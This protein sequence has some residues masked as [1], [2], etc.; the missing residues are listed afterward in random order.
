MDALYI[1]GPPSGTNLAA[2][3]LESRL[4]LT[5]VLGVSSPLGRIQSF[6]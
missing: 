1:L 5:Q 2:L 6:L 4:E 3:F